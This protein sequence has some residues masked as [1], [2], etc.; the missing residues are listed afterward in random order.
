MIKQQAARG[1]RDSETTLADLVLRYFWPTHIFQDASVGTAEEQWA[2]YRFNR[3][4]RIYLPHYG[5]VWSFFSLFLLIA[6]SAVPSAFPPTVTAEIAAMAILTAFTCSL[7]VLIV[8]V[9]AYVVFNRN[10]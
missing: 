9:V 8:V 6:G 2:K 3:E 5:R 7:S 4:R 10:E 1:V